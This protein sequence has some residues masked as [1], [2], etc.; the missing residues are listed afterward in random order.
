MPH[1][2]SV[3]EGPVMWQ[4]ALATDTLSSYTHDYPTL[5]ADV[6]EVI[7]QIYE[8]LSNVKLLERHRS[9][10]LCRQRGTRECDDLLR[11]KEWLDDNASWT[12]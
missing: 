3:A 7:H 2:C 10:C 12:Y 1:K 11:E 5:P 4:Q 6:A 8:D 9:S